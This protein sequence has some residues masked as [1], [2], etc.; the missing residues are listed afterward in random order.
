MPG[1]CDKRE[2]REGVR[3]VCRSVITEKD[4]AD[5]L[6]KEGS[7]DWRWLQAGELVVGSVG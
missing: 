5:N 7:K 2:A 6:C 4:R 3:A 1:G